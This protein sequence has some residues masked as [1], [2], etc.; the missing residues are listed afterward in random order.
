[1][2]S[3]AFIQQQFPHYIKLMR[4]DRPIGTYL[5]L[6]PTLWALWIAAEGIPDW[7]VLVI[8]ILGVYSMRAAGC[9]INDFADRKIDGHVERT[10]ERPLATGDVTAKEAIGLFIVLGLISFGLVLMTNPLTIL[11]S[12]GGILLA[13]MYPFMKR[14]THLPQVV[15][16]AAFSWAIPMA[17]AAQT[18]SVPVEAWLLFSAKLLW[19]VAYDTQYAM[20]D[21]N[22]D[23]K[24]GVKSTAILFGELDRHIIAL[25]QILA[26]IALLI[27][28]AHKGLGIWFYLGLAAACGLFIYQTKL[29]FHREREACF[30]AF[31]NNHWVGVLILL[32][33]ILDYALK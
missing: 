26:V 28:A 9:V 18:N 13:F 7:D 14:Y 30:K 4:V 31:L 22:D 16:G 5:L 3:V 33:I 24:I 12:L 6:W 17:Y 21:R 1:M 27:V 2:S 19:T 8:F 32:G 10:K 20:V 29:I 11:L 15:L 25:L 23:V